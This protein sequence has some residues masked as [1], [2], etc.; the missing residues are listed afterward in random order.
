M[1]IGLTWPLRGNTSHKPI[2]FAVTAH[3]RNSG[4]PRELMLVCSDVMPCHVHFHLINE[5][6]IYSGLLSVGGKKEKCIYF[7]MSIFSH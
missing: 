6:Y 3:G 4:L 1:G 2:N 5:A 7:L